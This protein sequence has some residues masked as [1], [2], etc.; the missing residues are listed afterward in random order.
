MRKIRNIEHI[1][2]DGVIQA[3]G[4]PEEDPS[5]HFDHGGWAFP[6]HDPAVG[7]AIDKAQGRGFG[8][9][10]GR[11]TY[12]IFALLAAGNRR[13]GRQPKRCPE[14]RRDASAGEPYRAADRT[15]YYSRG[16][17]GEKKHVCYDPSPAS[18][19]YQQP[20]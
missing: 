5:E 10:L 2:L 3:P 20:C 4:G 16:N 7:T 15:S 18:A 9:L 11:R 12:D 13:H 6:H 8:L 19:R 14:I 1:S 17:S